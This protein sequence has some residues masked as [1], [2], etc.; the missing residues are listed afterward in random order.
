MAVG[1]VSGD[2]SGLDYSY[3]VAI[4]NIIAA[5]SQPLE[6]LTTQLDTI[7]LQKSIYTDLNGMLTSFQNSVKS[8][9]STDAMYN[10]EPGRSAAFSGLTSGVKFGNASASSSATPASYQ[11]SVTNIAQEHR[12]RS[13]RQ[14]YVNQALGLSGSFLIGGAASRSQITQSTVAD[15]VTGFNTAEIAEGKAELG[16]GSYFV[17]MQQNSSGTWQ[18]RLVDAEGNAVSIKK[19][20]GSGDY[21]TAWQ[22]VPS[23]GGEIDTGRG[24]TFTLGADPLLY[25]AGIKGS[26][27]AQVDY[28]A[29][30]VEID[31]ETSHT[32][33]DIASKI[34]NVDYPEGNEVV[35][36]IVDNQLILSAKNSGEDHAVTL[37]DI[38]GNV[39]NSLGVLNGTAFKNQMQEGLNAHFSVNGLSVERSKNTGLTDVIHGVTLSLLKDSEGESATLAIESDPEKEREEVDTFVNQFNSLM[40][41]LTAKTSTKKN[42]DDTYTRGALAGDFIFTTLRYD[43][44]RLASNSQST[45]GAYSRLS[46]IGIT[47][48]DDLK[49]TVS[50]SSKFETALLNN[51]ADVEKLMD[52][53]MSAMDAKVGRFLGSS[54]YLTT[55]TNA[56]ERQIENANDQI[57]TFETRLSKRQESLILQYA[58]LQ[59]QL[60]TMTYQSQQFGA[61]YGSSSSSY[62]G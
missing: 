58:E 24:L 25:T 7:T 28:T 61:L 33:V 45:G 42:D 22:N 40:K 49:L 31:I 3:Q 52:S 53:V 18:Y 12:V 9:I 4:Q 47:M 50:D 46:E 55:A 13:D 59:S 21:S 10:F 11:L 5:E 1:S 60:M 38:S 19:S 29:Q 51:R 62:Y 2:Y 41:Y 48:D 27:A 23:G 43:L 56:A 15:T 35:A 14:A 8:L 16:S 17:E 54:G 34:N 36:T 39:M 6:R 37:S 57:S 26:G 44:L 30:G 32:L 20:N